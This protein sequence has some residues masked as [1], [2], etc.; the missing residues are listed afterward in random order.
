[1]CDSVIKNKGFYIGRYETG[2]K[3]GELKQNM[4]TKKYYWENGK[5]VVQKDVDIY[6]NIKWGTAMN[7]TTDGAVEKSKGFKIGKAYENSVTSTLIYGIQ[8]DATMQFF[9]NNYISGIS[10]IENLYVSNS[11]GKGNYKEDANTNDWKGQV[12]Q[13]GSL[14]E[15]SVKNIY[16]IAGNVWEW[17]MEA[18]STNN[19]IVRGGAYYESGSNYPVSLRHNYDPTSSYN[20]VGFRIALY[21][22]K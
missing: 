6:N 12:A 2:I 20:G 14:P 11:T 3:D 7:D 1:M 17:T 13:T 8:W 21:L 18:C 5:V 10:D 22:N 9:D 15:Y 16:D 19:R 4:E